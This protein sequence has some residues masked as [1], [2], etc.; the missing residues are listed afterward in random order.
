MSRQGFM[1]NKKNVSRKAAKSAK[2]SD[3]L[4]LFILSPW[5]CGFVRDDCNESIRVCS[6]LFAEIENISPAKPR[7]AAKGGHM[8]AKLPFS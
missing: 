6:R 3:Y 1:D 2:F 5:L 7:S 4:I 8:N